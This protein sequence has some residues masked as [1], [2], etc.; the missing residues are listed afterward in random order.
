MKTNDEK[1]LG[2]RISEALRDLGRIRA[3]NVARLE[4]VQ[5]DPGYAAFLRGRI[6]STEAEIEEIRMHG[7]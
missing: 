3:A 5:D 4:N 7:M 2:D 1:Y 6:S